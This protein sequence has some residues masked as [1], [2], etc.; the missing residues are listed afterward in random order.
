MYNIRSK[1]F[2]NNNR[3]D[4]FI[5]TGLLPGKT[6]FFEIDNVDINTDTPNQ[7]IQLHSSNISRKAIVCE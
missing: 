4:I 2:I 1:K 3:D 7:K 6:T 5:P